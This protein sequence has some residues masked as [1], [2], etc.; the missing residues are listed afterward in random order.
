M[1]AAMVAALGSL[2]LVGAGTARGQGL[3]ATGGEVAAAT[4]KR[5]E[6]RLRE[7]GIRLTAEDVKAIKTIENHR[8]RIMEL[9]RTLSK[10]DDAYA[11][12]GN[13]GRVAEIGGHKTH[14][15]LVQRQLPSADATVGGYYME[16]KRYLAGPSKKHREYVKAI[17]DDIAV[18]AR[19][20]KLDGT[21]GGGAKPSGGG[22]GG[23]TAGQD[24]EVYVISVSGEVEFYVNEQKVERAKQ[25]FALGGANSF[26][27]RAVAVGKRR[28]QSREFQT[29]PNTT[30]HAQSDYRLAYA[31]KSG[32]FSGET[33]W[34]VDDE[35][36]QWSVTRAPNMHAAVEVTTSNKHVT[37]EHDV[38]LFTFDGVF[39]YGAKVSGKVEWIGESERPGGKQSL[40]N[41]DQGTGAIMLTVGPKG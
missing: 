34:I 26:T 38:V 1:R 27:L 4:A 23:A 36:Y 25:A 5:V 17:D 6:E 3:I 14:L 41:Q 37:L 18:Y 9:Y 10:Y 21:G 13:T 39:S 29:R 22:G 30:L 24:L 2:L 8:N 32:N 16:L 15:R 35:R 20:V 31:V 33:D 12:E 11:K 19:E 40:K 28:K 7:A